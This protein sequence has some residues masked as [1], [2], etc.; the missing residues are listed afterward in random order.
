M[1][2]LQRWLVDLGESLPLRGRWLGYFV[3]VVL[4]GLGGLIF[5]VMI[6]NPPGYDPSVIISQLFGGC[7]MAIGL[8]VIVLS[9][10][11]KK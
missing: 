11:R 2:Q 7:M 5:P 3:G 9:H 10:T 1:R 8:G 4:M 6:T